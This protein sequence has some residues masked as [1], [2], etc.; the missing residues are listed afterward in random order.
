[1]SNSPQSEPSE[2]Q[3]NRLAELYYA[4]K[5]KETEQLCRELLRS[6]SDTLVV[7]DLL[8]AVLRGRGKLK[9]ALQIFNQ[10][11]E[12]NPN[13]EAY[14]R[15]SSV[16]TELGMIKEAIRDYEHALELEPNNAV[17][18]RNLAELK[19]Y[20][21]DDEQLKLMQEC[22]SDSDTDER[23]RIHLCF[24]LAKAHDDLN[25]FDNSFRYLTEGNR[26]HKQRLGYD[27][28]DDERLV[29]KIKRLFRSSTALPVVTDNKPRSKQPVF[30]IGMPRTGTSLVEQ[31]LASHSCIHGAGE[32]DFMRRLVEPILSKTDD[33]LLQKD[34][35]PLRSGYLDMLNALDTDNNIIIDK[36]PFNF[37]LL[38]FIL[39]A[40]PEARIIH[41]RR[42]PVATG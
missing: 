4:G 21:T 8:G 19:T 42:H 10:S 27:I 15:R 41:V 29:H 22:Y 14:N 12:I 18:H 3:L 24:A 23:Q 20:K 40:L 13:S 39:V 25:D 2:E 7:I 1:M 31:I 30:I 34:I 26:L 16:F 5:L 35:M 17:I 6:H 38:G 33:K 36:M 9:E 37:M 11:I 28:C 32:L